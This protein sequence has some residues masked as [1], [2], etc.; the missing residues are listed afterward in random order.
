MLRFVSTAGGDG[1]PPRVSSQMI[2][3][4]RGGAGMI[5]ACFG[6]VDMGSEV[7]HSFGLYERGCGAVQNGNVAFSLEPPGE[8]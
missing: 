8:I 1:Q 6:G 5:A 2:R 3:G 7:W 4:Q